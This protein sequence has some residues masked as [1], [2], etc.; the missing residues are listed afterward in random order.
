MGATTDPVWLVEMPGYTDA[1]TYTTERY[2]SRA[3][4]TMPG[5]TPPDVEYENRVLDPGTIRRRLFAE[6]Q[7]GARANPRA[8]VSVGDIKV[9]ALGGDLDARFDPTV[10]SFRERPIDIR[11]VEAGAS[12]STAVHVLRGIVDRVIKSREAFTIG[13]K[14]RL[15]ELDN[16]HLTTTFAG[17][18]VLPAG[19][20]GG[21]ELAG[22]PKP[23]IYG[24][25]LQ[26]E[27]ECANT[28]WLVYHLS[29]QAIQSVDSVTDGG[30]PL[31]AG[32]QRT[33]A[34]LDAA[35][36]S[37]TFTANA[38]S[39]QLTTGAAHG[40]TTG[41]PVSVSSSGALPAGLLATQYYWAR[42]V[43]G[44]L[45][46]LHPSAADAVAN[47]NV[48]DIT[49]AGSGT[50][51]LAANTTLAAHYDWCSD[52]AGSYIRLGGR[53]VYRLLVDVVGDTTANS[54]AAQIMKRLLLERG[55]DAGDI[56]AADVAALDVLN[57]AV[58]GW[59]ATS[60]TTLQL[61]D[62]FAA[63]VGASWWLDQVGVFRMQR[64]DLPTG[65]PVAVMGQAEG[66]TLHQV[67]SDEDVPTLDVR[68]EYA[69]YHATQR[70]NELAV[71]V[72]AADQ[73]DLAQEWR[74]AQHVGTLTPNPHKRTQVATRRTCLVYKADAEAEALRLFG[75]TSEPRRT[76]VL[77]G[78]EFDD[79]AMQA[80]DL[81]AVVELRWNRF[82]LDPVVGTLM[83]VIGIVFF[84]GSRK[85]DITLWG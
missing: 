49:T 32:V 37:V 66:A 4:W 64:F 28:H 53:P 11:M 46:T 75:I 3:W 39:D 69:H 62:M 61:V 16:L 74:V 73:A 27:P 80:L 71:S 9:N 82:L 38:V 30:V 79:V 78:M 54:T 34:Q 56:N 23:R 1:S 43:S 42:A 72:S 65:T 60:E 40:L 36:T 13:V 6:G 45:V 81:N 85:C 18:N 15:G 35:G 19:L 51:T 44:T 55:V 8:D 33:L 77:R 47:T 50:H 7:S 59:R 70:G 24:R 17:D 83:R 57:P 14:S 10:R 21:A 41:D 22:K 26:V 63:S 29:D 68:V 67:D 12:Y 58:C 52:A 48:V 5:D 20:E 84:L 31:T 25:V 2:A 76:F